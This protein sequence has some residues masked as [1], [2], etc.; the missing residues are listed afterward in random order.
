MISI[1][2]MTTTKCTNICL[3]SWK[4]NCPKVTIVKELSLNYW[5]RQM[6]LVSKQSNLSKNTI[7]CM[8]KEKINSIWLIHKSL[9]KLPIRLRFQCLIWV[10]FIFS[11]KKEMETQAKPQTNKKVK[12]RVSQIVLCNKISM[13][14]NQISII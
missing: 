5:K 1:N 7:N 2:C 3:R 12:K 9:L 13:I 4:L 14:L 10:S 8:S 6:N 11:S